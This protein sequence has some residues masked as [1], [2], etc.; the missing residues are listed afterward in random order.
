MPASQKRHSNI[1]ARTMPKLTWAWS[2]AI[3]AGNS[4][5][6]DHR[7]R[8]L[9]AAGL[10][11]GGQDGVRLLGKGAFTA[12][13][14]LSSQAFRPGQRRRLKR[15][16]VPATELHRPNNFPIIAGGVGVTPPALYGLLIPKGTRHRASANLAPSEHFRIMA[17]RA[18]QH[19]EQ[20][21]SLASFSR[22]P[23]SQ[24]A[25]GS[26]SVALIIFQFASFRCPAGISPIARKALHG[27][28]SGRI[29][30]FF[31]MFRAARSAHALISL[32]VILTSPPRS[33][34]S[35]PVRPSPRLGRAEGESGRK[36]QAQLWPVQTA[37]GWSSPQP[38][39]LCRAAQRA[40]YP[41][42]WV[43]GPLF[44][45]AGLISLVGG[46][47]PLVAGRAES[48][49]AGSVTAPRRSSRPGPW[50]C[51]FFKP[52]RWAPAR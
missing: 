31:N 37:M 19:R 4:T 44:Y 39:G 43:T 51:P 30:D 28:N 42:V 17:S 12:K 40:R 36:A 9:K 20:P 47:F 29:L 23:G 13:A 52:V 33:W 3:D 49:T 1:F 50:R 27:P 18:G 48:P 14:S 7:P 38:P 10:A 15:P 2:E 16:P 32:G 21:P 34:S 26:P 24:A 46:N 25:S 6:G 35:W 5:S 22:R 45:F 41:G 8:R 11:R